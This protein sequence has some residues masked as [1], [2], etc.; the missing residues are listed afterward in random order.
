M[1]LRVDFLEKGE[2]WVNVLLNNLWIISN[3][4]WRLMDWE[5]RN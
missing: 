3:F 1:I 2:N 4:C 5:I